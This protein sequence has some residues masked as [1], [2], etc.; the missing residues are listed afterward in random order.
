[1]KWASIVNHTGTTK[2]PIHLM[3]KLFM[4]LGIRADAKHHWEIEGTR[5]HI[6][7]IEDLKGAIREKATKTQPGINWLK[8]DTTTKGWSREEMKKARKP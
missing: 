1:M 3:S 7:E 5:K 8:P 4:Q 2:G 6:S